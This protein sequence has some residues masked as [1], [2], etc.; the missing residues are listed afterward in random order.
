MPMVKGGC[1]AR[2][3]SNAD[4]K[5]GVCHLEVWSPG[6]NLALLVAEVSAALEAHHA[7]VQRW[8]SHGLDGAIIPYEGLAPAAL[9]PLQRRLLSMG[10]WVWPACD[11]VQGDAL[12]GVVWVAW[13]DEVPWGLCPEKT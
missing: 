1:T 4:P 6:A 11:T 8:E 3:G 12:M 10:V 7:V 9:L 5:V 2:L 13:V